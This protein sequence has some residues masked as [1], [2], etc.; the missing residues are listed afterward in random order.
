MVRSGPVCKGALPRDRQFTMRNKSL[1]S[2]D[3]KDVGVIE[4]E[5]LIAR[6]R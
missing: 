5:R 2:A 4:I 3:V 6:R 1:A